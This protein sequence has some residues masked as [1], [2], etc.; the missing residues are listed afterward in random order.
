M[1]D[2]QPAQLII[3]G[4]ASTSALLRAFVGLRRKKEPRL[5]TTTTLRC[6]G[7]TILMSVFTEEAVLKQ[8]KMPD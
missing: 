3:T 6:P 2:G 1:P 8:R 7:E 4:D 5:D